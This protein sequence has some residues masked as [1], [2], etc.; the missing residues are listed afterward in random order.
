MTPDPHLPAKIATCTTLAELMSLR[1]HLKL[2]GRLD[3]AA[4][5]LIAVRQRELQGRHST[6]NR[7]A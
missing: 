6:Q 5:H 4:V 7:R 2:A 1:E 3:G